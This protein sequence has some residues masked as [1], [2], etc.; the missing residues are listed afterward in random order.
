MG[1]RTGKGEGE[2]PVLVGEDR[3]E[4]PTAFIHEGHLSQRNPEL[5][6]GVQDSALE[7]LGRELPCAEDEASQ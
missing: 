3:S 7:D 5:A 1:V 4:D 2:E 6:L